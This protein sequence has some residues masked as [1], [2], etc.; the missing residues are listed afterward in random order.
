MGRKQSTA[1]PHRAALEQ[2]LRELKLANPEAFQALQL[3][4]R[5]LVQER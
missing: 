4:V 2:K 1:L 3:I 5:S